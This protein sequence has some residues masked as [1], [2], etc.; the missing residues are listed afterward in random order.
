MTGSTKPSSLKESWR[1]SRPTI[2]LWLTAADP[3]AAEQV[4]SLGF[5]YVCLDLQH[6][7]FDE[8]RTVPTL[9]ALRT[10]TA[11][12][13]C[14]VAWNEPTPICRA[15][16]AGAGGVI[17]P[18]VNT[19]AEAERAVAACR[20]A[21]AGTRSFGPARA[22]TVFGPDYFDHAN[23][24]VACIP[25][26]ETATAVANVDDIVSVEG[27]DAVYV[28]PSDL[29]VSLGV[30]PGSDSDAT[31]FQEA[32]RH[33]VDTCERHGVVAGIHS[34]PELVPLRLE[35]GFKMVTAVSDV[36]ALMTGA[37]AALAE[38]HGSSS[39]RNSLA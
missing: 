11:V 39:Y 31:V 36:R 12:P 25:M 18:M 17:I 21:P 3:L 35:Q 30:G 37:A 23:D 10:S 8:S 7:L 13:L 32:I 29:G 6:G 5:D 26:I 4:G 9:Q 14:R 1:H 24:L 34:V 28:G 16:D 33:I 19:A 15:L 27:V 38:A 22:G 2:G 20:Y